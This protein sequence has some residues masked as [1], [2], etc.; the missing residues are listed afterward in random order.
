MQKA[1][2]RIIARSSYNSH[3]EPLY[4]KLQVLPLPDL[5]SFSKLHF[6][7]RF[8]QDYLPTSFNDTWARNAIRNI[9]DN[10][11][12]LQNFNQLQPIHSN[13]VSL[14]VFPLFNFPKLWQEF[15]NEQIKIIR[16]TAVFDTKLKKISL[17]LWR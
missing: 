8:W 4:K 9:G 13:L 11:I 3:T 2:I 16:K 14:D 1:A 6:M 17:M 10:D 15:P 5:I 12:Q 7:Q